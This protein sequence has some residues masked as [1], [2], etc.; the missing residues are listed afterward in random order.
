MKSFAPLVAFVA[1]CTAIVLSGC[2]TTNQKNASGFLTFCA[3]HN[4]TA[5]NV[6]QTTKAPWYSHTET[7]SGLT[8]VNG[9]TSVSDLKATLT[10][11]PMGVPA[12]SWEFSAD[13]ISISDADLPALAANAAPTK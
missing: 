2:A 10:L 5:A 12:A 3:T 6:T 13:A 8:K 7:L 1:V 11:Y 4:F 9:V